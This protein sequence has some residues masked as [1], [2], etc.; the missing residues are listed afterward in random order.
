MFS[1]VFKEAGTINGTN[2]EAIK[3]KMFRNDSFQGLSRLEVLDIRDFPLQV[4]QVSNIFK[5]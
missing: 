2:I 1:A 3:Q 4:F 5:F